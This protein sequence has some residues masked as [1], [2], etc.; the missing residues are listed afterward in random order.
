VCHKAS[1]HR[2]YT[3]VF[4]VRRIFELPPISS[5]AEW[6][7]VLHLAH[8]WNFES[9]RAYAIGKLA[10]ITTPVDRIVLGKKYAIDH[11]LH[12]A[13]RVVCERPTCLSDEEGARLGLADVLRI[14][15][16][17]Q[18]MRIP[19]LLR[20]SETQRSHAFYKTFGIPA[21]IPITS[22]ALAPQFESP[23]TQDDAMTRVA[24]PSTRCG[25]TKPTHVTPSAIHVSGE[26][27]TTSERDCAT[28]QP[29]VDDEPS[30]SE[31]VVLAPISE[32]VR[33]RLQSALTKIENAENGSRRAQQALEK[34]ESTLKDAEAAL[35]TARTASTNCKLYERRCADAQ[36]P[37][38]ANKNTIASWGKAAEQAHSALVALALADVK[39]DLRPYHVPADMRAALGQL[40]STIDS[41]RDVLLDT[42]EEYASQRDENNNMYLKSWKRM[43]ADN[44]TADTAQA[45]EDA[46]RQPELLK[47]RCARK[48]MDAENKIARSQRELAQLLSQ[49]AVAATSS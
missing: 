21:P 6:A 19:A 10:A 24:T 27:V 26:I 29:P 34:A 43:H 28:P 7:S 46:R 23:V 22:A 32:S 39:V 15:R 4:V 12:P 17:R 3:D 40:L 35:N 36:A 14:S 42:Q 11:W 9:M 48:I 16:A 2:I 38:D 18:D 20:S 45:L 8:T 5:K 41:T 31:L 13:Y 49:L 30:E 44:P 1:H 47:V 25:P 37:V 33:E